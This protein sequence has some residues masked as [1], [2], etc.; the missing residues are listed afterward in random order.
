[1]NTITTKYGTTYKIPNNLKE[2]YY[3][4]LM[5]KLIEFV[6]KEGLTVRQ[7]HELFVACSDMVMDAKL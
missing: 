4:E 5:Y 7:A 1:M 2:E 3:Y 6:K